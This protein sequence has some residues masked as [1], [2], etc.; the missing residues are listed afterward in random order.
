[1]NVS[2]ETAERLTLYEEQLIR[3]NPKINLVSSASIVDLQGRHFRDCLQLAELAGRPEG[4][5]VDI[6]S[7]GGLPG[8]VLAIALAQ[9]PVSFVL[10]ESDRRKAAFLRNV[11]REVALENV[12]V[13]N[14]RIELLPALNADYLSARA[15]APLPKLVAYL[16]RHLA[17][18]GKAFLMKGRRWRDEVQ[19]AMKVWEFSY[20][21]HPS[22]TEEGAAILEVSGIR[23]GA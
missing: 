18:H 17:P 21:T 1:M 19:D 20:I 11:V 23:H 2:R 12:Q 15:L 13:A 22:R 5:W 4:L 14:D 16:D 10:V 8:L 7:G 6:G 9:H 3:W